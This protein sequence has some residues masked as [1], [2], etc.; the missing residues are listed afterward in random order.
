MIAWQ[1]CAGL[2]LGLLLAGCSRS[3]SVPAPVMEAQRLIS[4]GKLLAA[5][6][7]LAACAARNP[8]TVEGAR[9]RF[10]LVIVRLDPAYPGPAAAAVEAGRSYLALEGAAPDRDAVV[11][12]TRLAAERVTLA[13]TMDSLRRAAAQR[14]TI[15]ETKVREAGDDTKLRAE[16]DRTRDELARTQEELQRIKKRLAS[17]RP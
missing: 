1:R 5:D 2:G 10:Y 6:S 4:A 7:S 12:L 14:D 3:A 11:V 15:I 9:C 16:L 13:G 8:G 17:P